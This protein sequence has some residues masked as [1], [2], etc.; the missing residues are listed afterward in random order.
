MQPK[1]VFSGFFTWSLRRGKP[2]RPTCI[3]NE[4]FLFSCAN[5]PSNLS[6]NG[7]LLFAKYSQLCQ[8]SSPSL[9][10]SAHRL[11]GREALVGQ[12]HFR[13]AL[14]ILEGNGDKGFRARIPTAL[15]GK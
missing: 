2:R 10:V 14:N 3:Q 1:R 4:S 13:S 9:F 5:H 8:R 12:S 7:K 6:L 15:P 11:R